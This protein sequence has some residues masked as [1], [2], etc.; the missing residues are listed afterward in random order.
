MCLILFSFEQHPMHR[1]VVAANRDEWFRR[2]AEPARFWADAPAVLAGRDTAHGGTWLGI[3]RSGRFAA[4]TNYREP[5]RFDAAAPSR[6]ALVS[7][8]LRGSATA[9]DHTAALQRTTAH[10]NGYSLIAYDGAEL[11]YVSNRAPAPGRLVPGVYGLS[12]HLLNT[13]WPKVTRGIAALS[14]LPDRYDV[15]GEL[16]ALLYD[17]RPAEDGRLPDTGLGLERERAV[18]ASHI[19]LG[20]ADDWTAVYGTRCASV[21]T[22]GRE[23][24]VDFEERTFTHTGQIDG[25]AAESFRID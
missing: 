16:F 24:V 21:V 8:F 1:L 11:Y 6:G 19:V 23:G 17:R 7:D 12:N 18:S 9:R 10:F 5:Q 4:L 22:I 20:P 14:A 25:I 15:A 2:A 3:S 13:P